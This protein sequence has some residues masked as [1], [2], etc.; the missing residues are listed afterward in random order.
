MDPLSYIDNAGIINIEELYIKYQSDATSVDSRW[1]KFF[2]GYDFAKTDYTETE[3][4]NYPL[5]IKAL[6]LILAYRERGHL[7]TK[8][9]PV[10]TRRKYSPTLDI[11]NFG[12]N[13]SDLKKV[14]KAGNLIGIGNSTLENIISHLNSIYCQSTGIEYMYIRMPEI[15][16]WFQKK[17]EARTDHSYSQKEKLHILEKLTQAVVFEKFI[18]GKFPGQK[19]FSLSGCETLIP[20]LDKLIE[21]GSDAGI[22]EFIIGMA[23]RGRLNVLA[24]ILHQ[25]YETIFSEFRGLEFDDSFLL[26][27][28]KYHLGYSSETKTKSGH[29]VKLG[30]VP[31]PSHLEALN[32]VVEGIVR[33]AIDK[34][35]NSSESIVPVLIHG[36]ASL[37]GQGII[38]EVL[39][40]SQLEGYKTG[41]TIHLVINNQIG[42]TT[43]YTDGRS[44]IYCT[45]VAKTIQVPVFHVNADD[46]E[47]ICNV[48]EIAV[49]FRQKFHRD[50]FIDLLGY[51]KFGHN[52]GDEPR[53]TQPLLYKLI[54]NHPDP[55]KIYIEKLIDEKILD[56]SSQQSIEKCLTTLFEGRFE[57]SV[58]IKKEHIF[59]F[60]EERWKHLNR[61]SSADFEESPDTFISNGTLLDLGKQ[62][63][64]LPD[65]ISFFKKTSKIIS[66]RRAM[67]ENEGHIDWALSE[68]LAWASL[69]NEG[70]NI[71][72]S[73]QDVERGTF[74]QRHAVLTIENSEEEYIPLSQINKDSAKFNIFNSLLSEY[75]VLGFEYG[76][77]VTSPDDLIIWEAQ[78]GDF[79][80]GAQIIFDQ[81]ISCAE[82]KWNVMTGLV[83]LLPHGYEGQGPEHSSGRM[84]RFL[85]LCA[86][87]NMQ[88]VNCTTPANYFHVLRRQLKRPFRKPLIIFTPKSLLRHPKCIS[89]LNEYTEGGFKEVID[90]GNPLPD[91]VKRIIFCSGKIYYDLAESKQQN[92]NTT[93]AIVRIEQIYPFPEKQFSEIISKYKSATEYLWVQE[94]PENMG[95]WPY[96]LRR[97]RD[98]PLEVIARPESG[99]TATGSA[100]IHQQQQKDILS[101]AFGVDG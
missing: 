79:A 97:L 54:E 63:T 32:P 96:I 29:N 50:I 87:N 14:F 3:T 82:E 76:Y 4:D 67:L 66:D 56:P 57:E 19:S 44:S 18:H 23:H 69:L 48:M 83:I 99:S 17:I 36:D 94:E 88:I 9:N 68:H 51:R 64:Q 12:L 70:H 75:G 74:S 39:Q 62:I 5:E 52:E 22:N 80:N 30:L 35:Y 43:N 33:S 31:N 28:V 6:N 15:V 78:Y 90:I 101:K 85:S 59:P 7:F 86:G 100:A 61:P 71:R 2:E 26:G 89:W 16:E 65:N 41:V 93:I 38:Y 13:K 27:D 81:Y 10:R 77:S 25:S 91:G 11:E 92:K 98:I 24:N 37:A 21:K 84:E 55:A 53:Y 42:F 95:A 1:Q 45:D 20:A 34:V 47:A 40:M 8:T 46:A 58:Q 49:E 60:L 73:G 72:V